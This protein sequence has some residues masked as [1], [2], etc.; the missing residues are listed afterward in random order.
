MASGE[1]LA[2]ATGTHEGRLQIYKYKHKF[3]CKGNKKD[4]FSYFTPGQRNK[5]NNNKQHNVQQQQQH[6]QENITITRRVQKLFAFLH[7]LRVSQRT[8]RES[9]KNECPA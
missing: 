2:E 8:H 1:Q 5:N 9:T 6:N 4:M 7:I 3:P